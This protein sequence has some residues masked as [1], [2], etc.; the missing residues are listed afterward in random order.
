MSELHIAQVNIARMKEPLD[1]PV[2]AGFVAR[3]EEINALADGSPGFVWR[4]QTGEGNATYLRPYDDERILFN[5]S[6]WKDIE[7]LKQYVYRTAHAELLRDRRSWFDQF[8]GASVALWWVP[9]GHIP[10]ID[11]AKERLAHLEAHGAT[12][13]AFTFKSLTASASGGAARPPALRA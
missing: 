7:S 1:S 4:L 10:S 5:L 8:A 2:M 11:E 6:V 3:L 12:E 9:A 13:F